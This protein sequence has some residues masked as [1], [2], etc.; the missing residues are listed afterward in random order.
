MI[1]GVVLLLAVIGADRSVHS[2]AYR[3]PSLAV[4][5]KAV[6][7][8]LAGSPDALT[9]K[10]ELGSDFRSAICVTIPVPGRDA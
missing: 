10:P 5:K 2:A 8:Y 9:I 7:A 1:A 3:M 6:A 4:C